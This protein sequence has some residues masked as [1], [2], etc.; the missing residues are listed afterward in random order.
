MTNVKKS[1]ALVMSLDE[2]SNCFEEPDHAS[3]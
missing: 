3:G 2:I 1:D